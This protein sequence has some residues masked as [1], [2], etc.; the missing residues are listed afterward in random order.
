V[1]DG[2]DND[3]DGETDET[4]PAGVTYFLLSARETASATHPQNSTNRTVVLAP[5]QTLEV[6]TCTIPETTASGD[7][8]L[9]LYS[10]DGVSVADNDEGQNCA[11]GASFLTHTVPAN[12]QGGTYV[13]RAGCFDDTSCGGTVGYRIF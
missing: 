7:T 8:Y 3:C 1:C 4:C 9:R 12:G 2:R 11:G 5:G 13:I 6:G 10:P